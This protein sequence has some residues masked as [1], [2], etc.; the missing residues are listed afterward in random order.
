MKN[1]IGRPRGRNYLTRKCLE[2]DN[3]FNTYPSQ[4]KLY[5]SNICGHALARQGKF[6][7]INKGKIPW[8]KGKTGLQKHSNKTKAIMRNKRLK[9]MEEN[10]G[11]FKDTDIEL[12]IKN[13]LNLEDIKFKQSKRIGKYCVDF[14]INKTIVECDG[15]YW[16]NR[17]G[18]KFKDF[19]RDSYLLSKGYTI[20]RFSEY[21]IKNNINACFNFLYS[22]I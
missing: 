12:L 7:E 2:C 9:Y 5:C 6:N 16:H 13:K 4:N 19:L 1:K 8:N 17:P 15:Y 14:L 22:V 11:K 18:D 20:L 21:N 3:I 10:I